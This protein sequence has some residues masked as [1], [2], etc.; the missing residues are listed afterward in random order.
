[1]RNPRGKTLVF[2][3]LCGLGAILVWVAI[4]RDDAVRDDGMTRA[5]GAT[6]ALL[7]MVCSIPAIQALSAWIGRARLLRGEGV[8]ARWPV[9]SQD[10]KQFLAFDKARGASDWQR[11]SNVMS[12]S[13][14]PDCPPQGIEV[15][16]GRT[17]ALIDDCYCAFPTIY[18]VQWLRIEGAAFNCLEIHLSNSHGAAWYPKLRVP[19]PRHAEAQ[20][21][22]A[23]QCYRSRILPGSLV[24]GPR[25]RAYRVARRLGL[26]GAILAA[27]GAWWGST[28]IQPVDP[29]D[30]MSMAPLL[31]AVIGCAAVAFSA[32]LAGLALFFGK[33]DA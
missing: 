1:M 25:S 19:V 27:I 31:L 20:A 21:T 24:S 11:L 30:F 14:R 3:L 26:G 29:Y 28:A 10:W 15:I 18:L 16:V 32:L 13:W 5:L 17:S 12:R 6:G 2:S 33:N 8:V 22:V 23:Y 7:L 9:S 4:E